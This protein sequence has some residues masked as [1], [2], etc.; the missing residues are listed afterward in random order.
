MQP[1]SSGGPPQPPPK[2]PKLTARGLLD[3][4]EPGKR[5][6]VQDYVVVKELAELLGLRPFKVVADVME[7]GQFKHADEVID[8]STAATIATK[9]GYVAERILP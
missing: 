9:H 3:P 4:G 8:F 7:L 2:P 5:L 6:F 1:A